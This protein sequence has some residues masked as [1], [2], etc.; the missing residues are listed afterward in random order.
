MMLF[1]A[2]YDEDVM[3][4]AE[5]IVPRAVTIRLKREEESLDNIKQYFVRCYCME[6][7]Y[8]ALTNIYGSIGIGQ[9]IIF[10]HT[11]KTAHWLS[12]RMSKD[13]HAVAILAGDLTVDQRIMILDRFRCGKEKVRISFSFLKHY[14]VIIAQ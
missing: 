10:C 7:K 9:A 6:D 3:Q 2:T 1:S 13:G 11:R 5:R 8:T 14:F 12:E 4:F